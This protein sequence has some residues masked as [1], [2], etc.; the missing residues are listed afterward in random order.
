MNDIFNFEVLQPII[1][2]NNYPL[3]RVFDDIFD[4]MVFPMVIISDENHPVFKEADK[5]KPKDK[6]IN[7]NH[8]ILTIRYKKEFLA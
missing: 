4:M 8:V 3:Y 2:T 1:V 6:N 7:L 5:S